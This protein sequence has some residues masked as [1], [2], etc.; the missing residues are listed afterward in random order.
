MLCFRLIS[1]LTLLFVEVTPVVKVDWIYHLSFRFAMIILRFFIYFLLQSD[2]W[3]KVLMT[4]CSVHDGEIA[5][6]MIVRDI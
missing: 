5:G 1:H 3:L 4:K 2:F 6:H